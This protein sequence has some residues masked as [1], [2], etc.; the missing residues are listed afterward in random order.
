MILTIKI[1]HRKR[2]MTNDYLDEFIAEINLESFLSWMK[3]NSKLFADNLYILGD[4]KNKKQLREWIKLFLLWSEYEDNK[5][6]E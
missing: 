5:N 2:K 4:D 1:N 3:V 6:G